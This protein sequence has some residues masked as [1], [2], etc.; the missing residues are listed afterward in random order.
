MLKILFTFDTCSLFCRFLHV[1]GKRT[2]VAV[3]GSNFLL[4]ESLELLP[5]LTTAGGASIDAVDAQELDG[6]RW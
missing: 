4:P 3:S 5:R 2:T 6:L 1:P